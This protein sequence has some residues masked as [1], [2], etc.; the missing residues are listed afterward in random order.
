MSFT[1]LSSGEKKK[2]VKTT[3]NGLPFTSGLFLSENTIAAG[4]FDKT[5]ITFKNNNSNW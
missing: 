5:P 4:G 2:A 1:D 3:H